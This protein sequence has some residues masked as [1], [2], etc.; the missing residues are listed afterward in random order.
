LW[1]GV[2]A[3][4][5]RIARGDADAAAELEPLWSLRAAPGLDQLGIQPWLP[6]FV[7]ALLLGEHG[8]LLHDA[9]DELD[10]RVA[11]D[12]QPGPLAVAARARATLL[13][14]AGDHRRAADVVAAALDDVDA[15][16][17]APEPF[18]QAML[19]L[20]LGMAL[21]RAGRRRAAVDHLRDAHKS[22]AALEA[23]PGLERCER[24]LA[25]C[26]LARAETGPRLRTRL[27]PQEL[28]VAHLVARG[29]TNREVAAEL[30]VSVKTVE[31][32]LG[33]IY[34]KLGVRARGGLAAALD[35]LG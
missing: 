24:E 22:L 27:T 32:H 9:L 8:T 6:V 11:E 14:A 5:L 18:E 28:A 25:S 16:P 17:L 1:W 4:R 26:G 29:M 12:P 20:A 13:S 10:R 2:A 7:D 3:A 19:E 15:S 31:Y 23:R 35:R 21:R 34:P 30:I 33:N